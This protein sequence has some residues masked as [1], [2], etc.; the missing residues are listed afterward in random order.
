MILVLKRERKDQYSI[1]L[2]TS[3]LFILT[4]EFIEKC[5]KHEFK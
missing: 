2:C 5:C 1:G 4:D 3:I